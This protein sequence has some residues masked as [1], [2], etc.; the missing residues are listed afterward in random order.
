[1]SMDAALQ[2]FFVEAQEHLESMENILLKFEDG[3]TDNDSLNDIFRSA[4][5]IKGSASIFA[6]THI[7]EFT[8]KVENVLDKARDNEITID[9]ELLNILFRCRDHIAELVEVSLEEYQA[10][11]TLIESSEILLSELAPWL[12]INTT[13]PEEKA[14]KTLEKPTAIDVSHQETITPSHNRS[15]WHISIR[16]TE[17]C[18]RNGMDPSSFLSFLASLGDITYIE[19]ITNNIPSLEQFDPENLYLGFELALQ[20]DSE[21][22]AI[23]NTFMFVKEDSIISILD[24]WAEQHQILQAIAE[25]PEDDTFLEGI[26]RQF[27]TLPAAEMDQAENIELEHD[28]ALI[29]AQLVSNLEDG[30]EELT[31]QLDPNEALNIQQQANNKEEAELAEKPEIEKALPKKE[32]KSN[33]PAADNINSQ[34]K[35]STKS[36]Q[37]KQIRIDANH[38]DHL[39]NLIGELVINQQ[40]ISLLTKQNESSA[41]NEAVDDYDSYTE[42]IREAALKLRMVPI[43]ATFQRFK[44]LV[45]DTA[46]ELNKDIELTLEGTETELDRLLVEKLVDP[47]TH[48]VRNAIDHGIES[49]EQREAAGKSLKGQIKLAAYHESG[50]IVIEISDDGKGIDVEKVTKKA[51]DKN[52]IALD[53]KLSDNEI[54]NLIFHPGFSTAET[55]TDLSGRGVGMD[56]VKRNVEA[57][58]GSIEITSKANEGSIFTIRLPLTLAII[59]GFHVKA[60]NTCFIIPQATIV[61]CIDL[62]SQDIIG[63]GTCL[64]IRG[65]MVPYILLKDIFQINSNVSTNDHSAKGE[66]IVVQFGSD[67]AGILVD[68]L[69]GEVQTVIKPLGPIFKPLKG[70]GGSSFLGNGDI[71]FILDI[72]Q[73]IELAVKQDNLNSS[74]HISENKDE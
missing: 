44:R 68:K 55:V 39:I 69:Y 4:H 6:L 1:M 46:K 64:N 52:I 45:R 11:P 26:F 14:D 35:G 20:T 27:G 50:H 32:T 16:L 25:L 49:V 47:I 8:H 23:E 54:L 56:V 67:V 60:A 40:R 2:A 66:L 33:K 19:T 42:Q 41:L 21:R 48:I 17:E 73:L 74:N 31:P 3:E 9:E 72:P 36:G 53:N 65:E 18:L 57:L 61:E 37:G 7:V 38:L 43:G 71:A 62:T 59:D 29:K 63:E 5:T 15:H 70:I 13:E 28:L 22:E 58:Q 51:L 30:T 24:P 12:N 34:A 10:N